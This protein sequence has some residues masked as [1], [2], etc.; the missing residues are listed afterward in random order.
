MVSVDSVLVGY[1]MINRAYGVC[2]ARD[3]LKILC[4]RRD[5]LRVYNNIKRSES[6]AEPRGG[7]FKY[8][9]A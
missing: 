8:Y 2:S 3:T 5:V 7:L 1:R 6:T 4:I 9:A